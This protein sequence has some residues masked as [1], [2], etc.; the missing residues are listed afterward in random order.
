[1]ID[2]AVASLPARG[3][4]RATNFLLLDRAQWDQSEQAVI[5]APV[6]CSIHWMGCVFSFDVRWGSS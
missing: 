3:S 6:G 5:N 4:P 1:M 2:G